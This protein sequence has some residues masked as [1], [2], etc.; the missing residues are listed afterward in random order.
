M[1]EVS[2]VGEESDYESDD[3]EIYDKYRYSHTHIKTRPD[4][5]DDVVRSVKAT[6]SDISVLSSSSDVVLFKTVD[7]VYVC[8]SIISDDGKEIYMLS[9]VEKSIKTIINLFDND[10]DVDVPVP[11]DTDIDIKTSI[12]DEVI[13]DYT[14][15]FGNLLDGL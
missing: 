6:Y 15:S 9:L 7:D 4:V 12:D 14:L 10:Y 3:S 5:I 13:S 1:S 2:I 11:A 8:V